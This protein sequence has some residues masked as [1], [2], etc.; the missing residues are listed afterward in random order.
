[1]ATQFRHQ[2]QQGKKVLG[3]CGLSGFEYCA[4]CGVCVCNC[5]SAQC[6]L[7]RICYVRYCPCDYR[8]RYLVIYVY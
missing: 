4:H 8:D 5:H 1:M 6:A 7:V 3:D 2:R